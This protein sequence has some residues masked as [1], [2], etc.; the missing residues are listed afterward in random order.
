MKPELTNARYKLV[1]YRIGETLCLSPSRSISAVMTVPANLTQVP[2]TK[3]W[4]LGAAKL[5][6]DLIPFINIARFLSIQSKPS[7]KGQP[8]L[9]VRG[10]ADIGSVGLLVDEVIGFLPTGDVRDLTNSELRIPPGLG[11]SLAGVVEGQDKVWAL[12]DLQQ[13]VSD[14]K[15]QKIDLN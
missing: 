10:Q 12:I 9:V 2:G 5:H 11:S 3:P 7:P 1:G 15:L 8:I 13:L 6:R 4:V 14:S